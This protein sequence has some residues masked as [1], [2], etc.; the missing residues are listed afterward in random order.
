M[1]IAL[2][3]CSFIPIHRVCIALFYA[4]SSMV[5]ETICILRLCMALLGRL[6]PPLGSSLQI[7]CCT[8]T[9]AQSPCPFVLGFCQ[10]LLGSLFIPICCLSQVL[11]HALAVIIGITHL[12]LGLSIPL[13]CLFE[14]HLERTFRCRG[15][16]FHR[17]GSRLLFRRSR[18][19]YNRS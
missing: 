1:D 11:F 10:T 7:L 13:F 15:R 3:R 19:S 18:L 5:A 6:L 16:C 14:K 4:F 8:L 9:I 17:R 12:E 2:F